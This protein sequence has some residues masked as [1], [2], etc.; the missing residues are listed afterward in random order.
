MTATQTKTRE[1][2][3]APTAT[4][5]IDKF[6]GTRL[7]YNTQFQEKFGVGAAAWNALCHTVYPHAKNVD[8]L[9]MVMAYCKARN[10]DPL[11]KPVHIVPM[12]DSKLGRYVETIWPSI[13]EIRITAHRTQSYAGC[14]AA[15]FGP[16]VT[17]S[18]TGKIRVR[19]EKDESGRSQSR[20]EEKTVG[21]SYPQWCQITVWRFVQGEPRKFVGPKVYWKETYASI[22]DSGVPNSMWERRSRGQL[23]KCAEAAALRKAFPE[24]LGTVYAAEEM[25]GRVR[26]DEA[27]A[28]AVVPDEPEEAPAAANGNGKAPSKLDAFGAAG[29]EV[30]EAEVVETEDPKKGKRKSKDEAGMVY[31]K[32]ESESQL[33]SLLDELNSPLSP[34]DLYEIAGRWRTSVIQM[35]PA[36][37]K[38]AQAV[39]EQRAMDVLDGDSEEGLP[40]FLTDKE[41]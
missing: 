10:L 11:K 36:H 17:E 38:Q 22:Q 4:R 21:V 26:D 16:D 24:E 6:H 33:A 5:E 35:L 18:F 7:T 39:L 13:S 30:E 14:D 20:S 28:A 23:E 9:V 8:A 27:I 29:D 3:Q 34:A 1:Q 40:T 25:A 12:Y 31:S 32:G 15:E 19:G 2:T 41:G 37:Q